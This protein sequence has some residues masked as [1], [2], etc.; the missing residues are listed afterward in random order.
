MTRQF[1]KWCTAFCAFT[2]FPLFSL[3]ATAQVK[4]SGTVIDDASL[5]LIGVS[6][7]E[8]GTT[9]GTMTDLDGNYTLTVANANVTLVFTYIGF[10]TKSVALKG[11][12]I[13]NISLEQDTK[14]L[15]EVI[16]V[17][18][19]VQNKMSV[20]AAISQMDG[21]ELLK[22]PMANV[23]NLLAG[24]VGGV[25]ALQQSGQPGSDGSSLLVRG[26][27]AVY[28]VDGVVRD[29]S[30]INPNDIATIS[31]LKDAAS[32]AVFGMDASSVIIV[33]TKRG[34]EGKS[35]ITFNAEY[36]VSQNA[37]MLDFLDGPQYAYW[38]N[39][40]REMDGDSPIFTD[41]HVRN[42]MAG[43][44]GWGNTNWYK[45][46]FGTG[47]NLN[48]NVNASGGTEKLKYFV[49]IGNF[50]QDGNVE[51]FKYNRLTLRSNID[52][53]IAKN[54]ELTF[55]ISGRIHK[56]NQ[57][58]FSA[59][60]SD[61]QNIPQ[62]AIRML[63]YVPEE[64][65]GLPIST[66]NSSSYAN[67]LAASTHSGYYK[68]RNNSI[69]TDL[70]L[71]YNIPFLEGLSAKFKISY[72]FADQMSKQFATPYYTMIAT[73]PANTDGDISYSKAYDARG[74][75]ATLTEGAFH[76]LNLLTN[77][78]INYAHKFG[79]HDVA[80]LFLFESRQY[81][82]N[83]FSAHGAGFPILAL[84][85]MN[86][87]SIPEKKSVSGMSGQTRLAGFVGRLNYGYDNKYFVEVSSRYDGSYKFGG[88]NINGKRYI[89]TPAA[90]FAWRISEEPWLKDQTTFLDNFKLRA[91][92]GK[93]A[94]TSGVGEYF[95][96][97]QLL[98]L[99]NIAVI[100][101]KPVSGL[102]TSNPANINLTWGNIYS[103]NVGFDFTLWKGFLD[104]EFDVFYKYLNKMPL[105][106]AS[107]YPDSFGGFYHALRNEFKQDHKGFE[108]VVRHKNKI[109][110][111]NYNIAVT[112]SY[113][114]RRWLKYADSPNT[115]DHLKLTGKAVG[116][117]VGFIADGL[118]QSQEEIDNSALIPGKAV[119][120]GDIKYV[121]RNG[122]GV[123]S[124]EQDRGYVAKSDYP[125]FS[126]GVNIE[127]EWKGIDFS[128][129]FQSGLGRDVALTGVYSSGVMDNTFLTK[130]FYHSGNSPV[131]LLEKSWTEDNRGAEFPRLSLVQA[132]S[133]NAYSSTFWYRNGN[134]LRMKSLQIGYTIPRALLSKA[135]IGSLRIYAEG[136]NL[137]TISELTKYG[138]DPEQPGVN[139]GYYPQQRVFAGGVKLTF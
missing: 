135:G 123:I 113:T 86:Y 125:I 2:L 58:G 120:V 92:L 46:T 41:A 65:D 51:G 84:D 3:A 9:N 50:Q 81:D 12:Q 17:G 89:L 119:R 67:P 72:D 77:T 101:G 96:L 93:Q 138:V 26:T 136:Q 22:A 121:D 29:F 106:V 90:S 108:F 127:G 124:Y 117:R 103:Y 20:S 43:E 57:P 79:K 42:M 98:P 130:P 94:S 134:Y 11:K 133:N 33:T 74:D 61:W 91:G 116:S 105:A 118:F 107:E 37:L 23:T 14:L 44:G 27:G 139:N 53:Q 8:K 28:V 39:K 54:L 18:Y 62:Q 99:P 25:I 112:G 21:D 115:P 111:F 71:K 36:G 104:V 97:D 40:A 128:M 114:N 38:Y 5:P 78:S 48:V 32:A 69:T 4:V 15:D 88:K 30:E 129:L 63:P 13:L 1:L 16:V 34:E 35:T 19:G 6:V 45:K 52:A 76:G 132:S 70:G 64:M 68:V 24:R 109:G 100:G 122:D 83:S 102:N 80:G 10:N 47:N 60:P 56:R 75:V 110:N 49:S 82:N 31:V 73:A 7:V 95:F 131:F 59:N 85:E 66:R 137:F 87:E 55:D 126:G